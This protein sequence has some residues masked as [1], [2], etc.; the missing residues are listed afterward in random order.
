MQPQG[1]DPQTYASVELVSGPTVAGEGAVVSARVTDATELR[2]HLLAGERRAAVGAIA[3]PAGRRVAVTLTMA[4]DDGARATLADVGVLRVRLVLDA[5]AGTAQGQ[6]LERATVLVSRPRPTFQ[7]TGRRR[8]GGFGGQLLEGT[9]AGDL[10]QGGHRH[11]VH[12]LAITYRLPGR[13]LTGWPQRRNGS[14]VVELVRRPTPVR[15]RPRPVSDQRRDRRC[16]I[17]GPMYATVACGA[18]SGPFGEKWIRPA[19][20]V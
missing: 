17:F 13:S 9:A 4:L 1:A 2:G 19:P 20:G 15:H 14:V 5:F 12:R 8:S 6:H 16:S 7:R 3:V 11:R 10:L 18:T